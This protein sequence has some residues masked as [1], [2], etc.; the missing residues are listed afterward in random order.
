VRRPQAPYDEAIARLELEMIQ[1]TDSPGWRAFT[2]AVQDIANQAQRRLEAGPLTGADLPAMYAHVTTVSTCKEILDLPKKLT[3]MS[4]QE[5][6][7]LETPGAPDV[8]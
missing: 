8:A 7:K 1:L 4:R 6:Q 5:R 3:A 2:A